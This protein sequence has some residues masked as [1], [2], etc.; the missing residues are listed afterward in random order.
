[1]Y[2]VFCVVYYIVFVHYIIISISV[3][4]ESPTM[5]MDAVQKEKMTCKVGNKDSSKWPILF[6]NENKMQ[7]NG[8]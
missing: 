7:E 4:N 5:V 1:M 2:K 8:E 6:E 3:Q